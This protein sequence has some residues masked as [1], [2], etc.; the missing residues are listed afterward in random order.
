MTRETKDLDEAIKVSRITLEADADFNEEDS[1]HLEALADALFMRYSITG[2]KRDAFEMAER[3]SARLRETIHEEQ[4]LQRLAETLLCLYQSTGMVE[5]LDESLKVSKQAID[6]YSESKAFRVRCRT[7]RG[8]ILFRKYQDNQDLTTLDEAIDIAANVAK[9]LTGPF[10][11]SNASLRNLFFDNW[12]IVTAA[13]PTSIQLAE[14]LK[15]PACVPV[16]GVTR[17]SYLD[18]LQQRLYERYERRGTSGDLEECGRILTQ[19]V[20]MIPSPPLLLCLS[21]RLFQLYLDN[22]FPF[23]LA[24][25]TKILRKLVEESEETVQQTEYSLYLSGALCLHHEL[26]GDISELNA[27]ILI[28][29]DIF[30]TTKLGDECH[31]LV[32][33]LV[34]DVF[35]QRCRADYT[36][37]NIEQTIHVM[38][39]MLDAEWSPTK[40]LSRMTQCFLW[41]YRLTG[42]VSLLDRAVQSGQRAVDSLPKKYPRHHCIITH[43]LALSL[44]ERYLNSG[45]MS[46]LEDAIRLERQNQSALDQTSKLSPVHL[47]ALLSV[48]Y[49][50][51]GD[52]IHLEES[53]SL[54]H[55][56]TPINDNRYS[57]CILGAHGVIPD[58]LTL[59]QT[60]GIISLIRDTL[61]AM[62]DS[63]PRKPRCLSGLA[64]IMSRGMETDA[65]IQFA[66]DA[67]RLASN[68][69]ANVSWHLCCLVL[70]LDSSF[71]LTGRASELVE[72]TTTAERAAKIASPDHPGKPFYYLVL[73]I[74]I[75][76]RFGA[77][78]RPMDLNR[79]IEY[80][81]KSFR[82]AHGKTIQDHYNRFLSSYQL[83]FCLQDKYLREGNS[84]DL[85]QADKLRSTAWVC[86]RVL[87]QDGA[88]LAWLCKSFEGACSIHLGTNEKVEFKLQNRTRVYAILL[89]ELNCNGRLYTLAKHYFNYYQEFKSKHYL[90]SSLRFCNTSLAYINEDYHTAYI[91]RLYLRGRYYEEYRNL[92]CSNPSEDINRS[93]KINDLREAISIFRKS[94]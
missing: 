46:D 81:L 89:D 10:P 94:H 41:K 64:L 66:R 53:M 76:R 30:E 83:S 37:Y 47:A 9:L 72:M 21:Q 42:D 93:D 86:E 36:L 84:S 12:V 61:E 49:A 69:D 45:R 43:R 24:R 52:I 92:S 50:A 48:L 22:G 27:A 88:Y 74:T 4:V 71:R 57:L 34:G 6:L 14:A 59:K 39:M 77:T 73:S 58:L 60:E 87:Q 18:K 26:T 56:N 79:A 40:A 90:S 38:E 67:V 62:E 68:H 55:E 80:G 5:H 70:C 11:L 8:D 15:W 23:W 25:S 32:L 7:F 65:A 75:Y 17:I 20:D 1:V 28:A 63:D 16:F 31:S 51:T 91:E 2:D 3:L 29:T 33:N 85:E 82:L 19:M 78:G 44:H 54:A 35:F 13:Y